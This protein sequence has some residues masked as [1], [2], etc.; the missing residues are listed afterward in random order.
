MIRSFKDPDDRSLRRQVSLFL[1]IRYLLNFPI[2]FLGC[3]WWSTNIG[4]QEHQKK[5]TKWRFMSSSRSFTT[6]FRKRS[7]NKVCPNSKM[8]KKDFKEASKNKSYTSHN[9]TPFD[10]LLILQSPFRFFNRILRVRA[11]KNT[12]TSKYRKGEVIVDD[13]GLTLVTRSGAY[14]QT[15]GWGVSVA[16]KRFQGSGETSRNR[17][18]KM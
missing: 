7:F 17:T 2:W 16:S 6:F 11:R 8:L 14:G 15:L 12:Q 5:E 13:E 9:T 4:A 10:G 1:S 18:S 3:G